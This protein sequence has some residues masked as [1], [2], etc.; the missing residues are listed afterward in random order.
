M[1]YLSFDERN[2]NRYPNFA[3]RSKDVNTNSN[4]Q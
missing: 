2:G 3:N 4:E 1:A